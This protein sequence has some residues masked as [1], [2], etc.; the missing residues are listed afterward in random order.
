VLRDRSEEVNVHLRSG[1]LVPDH[2][3]VRLALVNR[4]QAR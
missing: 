1:G 4:Q 3:R 2:A